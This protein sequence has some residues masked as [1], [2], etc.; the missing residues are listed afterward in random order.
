MAVLFFI[1]MFS[2]L[3]PTVYRNACIRYCKTMHSHAQDTLAYTETHTH[4][5]KLDSRLGAIRPSFRNSCIVIPSQTQR[6]AWLEPSSTYIYVRPLTVKR[7][8][9]RWEN[10][11]QR[12]RETERETLDYGT[13]KLLVCVFI[14]TSRSTRI[15]IQVCLP[16]ALLPK[17]TLPHGPPCAYIHTMR[18]R[19]HKTFERSS[20]TIL[21]FPSLS[22]TTF[23]TFGKMKYHRAAT[24]KTS[25]SKTLRVI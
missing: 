12:A 16:T 22:E 25:H 21:H 18:P 15:T 11:L 10:G 2:F 23:L 3:P 1:F 5:H 6:R 9:K 14:A 7:N 4:L 8:R 13:R 19:T 17:L 20:S 24:T